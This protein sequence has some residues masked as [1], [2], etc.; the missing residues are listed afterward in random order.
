M[1]YLRSLSMLWHFASQRHDTMIMKLLGSPLLCILADYY[2]DGT[3][4]EAK[5]R[6]V[7]NDTL[8][9]KP[10]MSNSSLP[11]Q[12]CSHLDIFFIFCL[13]IIHT[14]IHI[15]RSSLFPMTLYMPLYCFNTLHFWECQNL[16]H[17]KT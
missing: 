10:A 2:H 8:M 4:K 16:Y 12:I 3:F 5:D 11:Q 6:H 7:G 15:Y 17:F 14:Y 1:P 13:H 9:V